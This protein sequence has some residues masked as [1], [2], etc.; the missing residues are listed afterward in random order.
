LAIGCERHYFEANIPVWGLFLGCIILA[1]FSCSGCIIA[2]TTLADSVGAENL[3]KVLGL[4]MPFV[5]AGAISGPVVSNS[6]LELIGY[7]TTWAVSLVCSL[8]I[9]ER[10]S[11]ELPAL[12][13]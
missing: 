11:T 9:S 4:A 2:F 3:G 8:S 7:W 13:R 10:P 6:L 1:V 12:L 5:K